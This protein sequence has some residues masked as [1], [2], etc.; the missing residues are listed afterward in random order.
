MNTQFVSIVVMIVTENIGWTSMYIATRRMGLKGSSA[1]RPSVAL[2]LKISFPLLITTKV[3]EKG[4]KSWL[5]VNAGG[6]NCYKLCVITLMLRCCRRRCRRFGFFPDGLPPR[7][8]R[9]RRWLRRRQL[10]ST[11]RGACIL[12]F[13][14]W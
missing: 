4:N 3:C 7:R 2:N 8:N 6:G 13:W 10:D 12:T 14:L 9:L 1:Q 5:S 11:N